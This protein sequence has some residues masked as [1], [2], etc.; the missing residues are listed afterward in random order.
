MINKAIIVAPQYVDA[1]PAYGIAD[2]HHVTY[3]IMLLSGLF[4]EVTNLFIDTPGIDINKDILLPENQADLYVFVFFGDSN[5]NPSPETIAKLSGKKVF[6]WPD[7]VW[8]W[9]YPTIKSVNQYADLHLSHDLP[10][11]T[12]INFCKPKNIYNF[13]L[14]LDTA[15]YYPDNDKQYDIAFIGTPYPPRDYYIKTL[16]TNIGYISNKIGRQLL[17]IIGTGNRG[18]NF[19]KEEL[20]RILRKSRIGLNFSRSPSGNDQLKCRTH[21]TI[22]CATL[23]LQ[24]QSTETAKY[25]TPGKD[26]IE[27]TSEVDMVKK[28]IYYLNNETERA[29]L[30]NSANVRLRE[31]C[32]PVQYWTKV[33]ELI[34]E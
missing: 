5:L 34:N 3:R 2:I 16:L 24:N 12:I 32:N 8:P 11:D 18:N 13:G 33:L 20:C 15:L 22:S 10:S 14:P 7:T 1:N 4:K 9:I 19:S 23:L 28:I 26:Y 17:P 31:R 6:V 21:E 27:F 25:Y 29:T 30:A